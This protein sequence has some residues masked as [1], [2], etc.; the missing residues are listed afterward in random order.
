MYMRRV[1][2]PG[3]ADKRLGDARHRRSGRHVRRQPGAGQDVSPT[4]ATLVLPISRGRREVATTPPRQSWLVPAQ[5]LGS[6]LASWVHI[7]LPDAIFF[8]GGVSGAGEL[9]LEPARATMASLASPTCLERVQVFDAAP[10][11]LTQ[12]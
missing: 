2:L 5:A 11:V 10:W 7:Y 3:V 6:A 12:E 1:R 9:L 4:A 8:G